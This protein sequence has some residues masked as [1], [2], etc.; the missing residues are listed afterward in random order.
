MTLAKPHTFSDNFINGTTDTGVWRR[1]VTA[2]RI[3]VTA[4]TEQLDVGCVLKAT[5]TSAGFSSAANPGTY[6]CPSG[7][8]GTWYA[9]K[10]SG[11]TSN[12]V[13]PSDTNGW[14]SR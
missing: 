2:I 1:T 12:A 10:N 11:S 7:L 5:I 14:S 3:K 4:S 13:T 6:K 8:T 9:I